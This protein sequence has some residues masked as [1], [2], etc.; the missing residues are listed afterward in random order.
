MYK[1]DL[2]LLIRWWMLGLGILPKVCFVKVANNQIA[3]TYSCVLL[4]TVKKAL[5]TDCVKFWLVVYGVFS[6]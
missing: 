6:G 3:W 1:F 2:V 5:Q 4:L